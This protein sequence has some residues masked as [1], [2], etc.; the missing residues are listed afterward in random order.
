MNQSWDIKI[1]IK[2]SNE[3]QY[4]YVQIMLIDYKLEYRSEYSVDINLIIWHMFGTW[5][6]FLGYY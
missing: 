3:E 4:Y 1:K 2:S 5:D 6:I